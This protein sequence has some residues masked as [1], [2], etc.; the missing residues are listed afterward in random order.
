M[1][2]YQLMNEAASYSFDGKDLLSNSMAAESLHRIFPNRDVQQWSMWLQNNRNQSR[3]VPY[4]IPFVRMHGGVFYEVEELNRF[5]DWERARSLGTIKLSGRAAEALAAYGVGSDN[6][7]A[8]GR[9]LAYT[10][11]PAVTEEGEPFVRLMTEKPLAVYRLEIAQAL[12]LANELVEATKYLRQG[13]T[14]GD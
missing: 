7:G 1:L 10:V 12:A 4:R 2:H 11:M 14:D 5:A 6:G 3:S 9:S 13:A 8:Y